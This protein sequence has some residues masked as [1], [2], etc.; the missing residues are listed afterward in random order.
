[1]GKDP[2]PAPQLPPSC[3]PPRATR[4]NPPAVRKPPAGPARSFGFSGSIAR[5]VFP[6]SGGPRNT[7]FSFRWSNSSPWS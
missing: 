2:Q 1:M 6:T 7:T 3:P 5:C 4:P